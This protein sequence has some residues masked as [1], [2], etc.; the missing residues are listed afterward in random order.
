MKN[1]VFLGLASFFT[2]LNKIALL[3]ASSWVSILVARIIDR[4]GKGIH[5]APRDV[6]VSESAGSNSL[7][8]SFGFHKAL[9]MAGAALGILITYFLPTGSNGAYDYKKLFFLSVIPVVLGLCMFFFIIRRRSGSNRK[10][11]GQPFG[12]TSGGSMTSSNYTLL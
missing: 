9:D 12:K 7:G 4:L 5:T 6:L 2:D 3:F 8:K 11:T 1:I 10:T